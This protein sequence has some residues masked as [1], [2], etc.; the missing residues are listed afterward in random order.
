M[1]NR[2]ATDAGESSNSVGPAIPPLLPV[3]PRLLTQTALQFVRSDM[4]RP[5]VVRQIQGLRT[6]LAAARALANG[7]FVSRAVETIHAV[8]GA[9][10]PLETALVRAS[11]ESA[12]GVSGARVMGPAGALDPRSLRISQ[13]TSMQIHAG[14]AV[15]AG[16][17]ALAWAA[18][19]AQGWRWR[20]AR[21]E[22]EMMRI[23]D[24]ARGASSARG[25]AEATEM[26]QL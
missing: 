10:R 12:R 11:R 4:S 22:A 17:A 25:S 16:G 24:S 3:R 9:M 6:S 2:S 23:G 1:G 7:G 5:H 8:S 21:F 15:A 19:R 14:P 18:W 26:E 20:W 13:T